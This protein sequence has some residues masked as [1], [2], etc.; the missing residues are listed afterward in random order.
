MLFSTQ[1]NRKAVTVKGSIR[2]NEIQ[3]KTFLLNFYYLHLYTIYEEKNL[4]TC[5]V[6]NTLKLVLR[7][8]ICKEEKVSV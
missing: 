5:H 3:K 2:M 4:M 7:C 1:S 6:S 8:H